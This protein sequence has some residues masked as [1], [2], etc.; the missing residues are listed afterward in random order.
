MC[1]CACVC[2]C[3]RVR[4]RVHVRACVRACVRVC[5]CVSVCVCACVRVC[6]G[7]VVKKHPCLIIAH[8]LAEILTRSCVANK[9][10]TYRV[11]NINQITHLKLTRAF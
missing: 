2:V 7:V 3:V 1:V 6:T 11:S 8:Y 5:V 9:P 10:V 4:V